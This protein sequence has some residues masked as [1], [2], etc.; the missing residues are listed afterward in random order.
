ML[1]QLSEVLN[2]DELGRIQGELGGAQWHDGRATAGSQA[3]LAKQNEQ[4]A[5]DA[6]A[7]LAA[8]Q[9]ILQALDRHPVF[10]SAALPAR[11]FPPQFNRYGGHANAYGNHVDGAIM[12]SATSGQRVRSDISCT[13]FLSEPDEYDGGELVIEDTYGRKVVKL[14]AGDAVLYPSGSVHRVEP[15]TRGYRT[16]S[17]FWVQ[18]MVRSDEQR[19]MLFEFDMNIMRLRQDAAHDHPAL[20]GITSTYHNL[21]R[22]WADL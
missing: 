8:R 7:S 22:M 18:S 14:P 19:K 20:V 2:R 9:L 16:A 21:L 13:V 6:P 4:L 5:P 12:H 17:F 11:V 3:A 15:V 1:L 10:L